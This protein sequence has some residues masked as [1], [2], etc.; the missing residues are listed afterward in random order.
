MSGLAVVVAALVTGVVAWF[1]TRSDDPPPQR[2]LVDQ[3]IA[4]YERS[5]NA[6]YHLEG[7]FTRTMPDGR[8]L[9]SA[10]AE[11]QRPPDELHWRLGSIGGR[12]R[13]TTVNCSTT[14][15]GEVECPPGAP[16]PDWQTETEKEVAALRSHFDWQPARP[17]TVSVDEDGCY[18]ITRAP[19]YPHPG[20][21]V[22]ALMCFDPAT[23]ALS[24]L[25][26]EHE[27]GARDRYEAATIRAEVHDS[28]F[29]LPDEP[30]PPPGVGG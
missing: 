3:L 20:E 24:V 4:D 13:G 10:W 26:L 17:F 15:D 8:Q 16:V 30:G 14:P 18:V 9:S 23:G 1:T 19:W 2:E 6:T 5:R 25:E 11:V 7:T 12:L 28:D 21:G 22:P 29:V 27:G